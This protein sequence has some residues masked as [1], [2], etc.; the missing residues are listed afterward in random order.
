MSSDSADPVSERVASHAAVPFEDARFLRAMLE[1]IPAFVLRVDP[2]GR[3]S[4]INQ[5][6]SGMQLEQVIGAPARAFVAEADLEN[7]EA[8]LGQAMLSGQPGYYQA[9]GVSAVNE[10]KPA[11]YDCHVVPI[12]QEDGRRAACIVALDVSE[13]LA[14][15]RDLEES[16]AKL[17]LALEA[18]GLGL[19]IWD[20]KNDRVELDQRTIELFGYE[21]KTASE[22]ISRIVHPDDRERIAEEV[23][24]TRGGRPTFP[25]HRIQR[26]DGEVRW[27]MTRGAL[28][29]DAEGDAVRLIGGI[30][31]ITARQ[32][33][34]QHLRKMQKLDAMGSLTAGVAHNFNNMLS[35]IGPA[36]DLALRSATHPNRAAFQ[37]AQHAL[38]RAAELVKQLTTFAGQ[39]RDAP[40]ERRNLV[41]L[42]ERAVSM[43]S[44]TFGETRI[45][46]D[47]PEQLA[48]VEC[49][50]AGIEQVVVNL[51]IN[52]RDALA[53]GARPARIEVDMAEVFATPPDA[54]PGPAKEYVRIR[55]RDNGSGIPEAVRPRLFEPFFTTKEDGKGT[56]LGLATSHA[57]VRSHGGFMSIEPQEQSGTA[58]ALFLPLLRT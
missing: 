45:T 47:K 24:N 30:I 4:Y 7:Y 14:R 35:V 29:H 1:A 41:P 56:G 22:Y 33:A 57:I 54:Q 42:V 25:E 50:A 3:I 15:A 28:I 31:D 40:I 10:G 26:P 11:Y 51:L 12:E 21:P 44:H 58:A 46:F 38:D 32:Q 23:G 20:L 36:L 6:R 48:D 39:G 5:L 9:R 19:F 27:V 55:V 52:A 17:R 43:C 13:R 49:D 8:A 18:T 37:D 34:E 2:E 53:N 16:E